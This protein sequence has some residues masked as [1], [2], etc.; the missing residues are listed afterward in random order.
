MYPD[1]STVNATTDVS[2]ILVYVND[3]T[4]GYAMPMVLLGFFIITMLGGFFAQLRFRG[5]GRIDFAFT[6]AGFT[7][8]GLAVI[9]SSKNGLLNPVYLFI[10]LGV[11]IL[12]VIWLY[13]ASE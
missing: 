11:S 7:T 3:I 10:S 4:Y 12:G 9:M 1:L 8:F 13:L 2:N 6:V 5:T